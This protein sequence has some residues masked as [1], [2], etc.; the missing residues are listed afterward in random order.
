MEAAN[1]N[2]PKRKIHVEKVEESEEEKKQ[3]ETESKKLDDDESAMSKMLDSASDATKKSI[4]KFGKSIEKSNS[5]K[6]LKVAK[7]GKKGKKEDGTM[8]EQGG[9]GS[10]SGANSKRVKSRTSSSKNKKSDK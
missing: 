10:Q 7:K 6:M 3:A 5:Q 9:D 1:K 2:S 8:T 4:N